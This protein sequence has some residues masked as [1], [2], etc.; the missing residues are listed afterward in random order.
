MAK[1]LGFSRA[2]SGTPID[3]GYVGR[4]KSTGCVN[5][6]RRWHRRIPSQVKVISRG[7]LCL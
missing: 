1:T 2:K 3:E 6:G 4:A 5:S 7:F